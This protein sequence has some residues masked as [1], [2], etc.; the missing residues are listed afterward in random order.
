MQSKERLS[1]VSSILPD[2]KAVPTPLMLSASQSELRDMMNGETGKL[3]ELR[4]ELE[5]DMEIVSEEFISSH[6]FDTNYACLWKIRNK[7]SD[8]QIK[9]EDFV[10]M[11][12]EV[13]E[14][15]T[16]LDEWTE[17]ISN[18]GKLV[19]KYVNEMTDIALQKSAK[20]PPKPKPKPVKI[21][22]ASEKA[23]NTKWMKDFTEKNHIG[24][25]YSGCTY[26][27]KAGH[28]YLFKTRNIDQVPSSQVQTA[29][30]V[31]EAAVGNHGQHLPDDALPGQ[32]AAVDHPG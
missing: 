16:V 27:D 18:I 3:L 21:A 25:Q 29:S 17:E 31:E 6:D 32:A 28:S 19:K 13:L 14:D 24:C 22:S 4:G 15:A 30:V 10:D 7:R 2:S 5:K 23:A 1:W 20:P 11:F 9:I 8:Y 26:V 12:S